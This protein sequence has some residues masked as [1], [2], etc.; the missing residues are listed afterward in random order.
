MGLIKLIED[1]L[2]SP[3]KLIQD[4]LRLHLFLSDSFTLNA[5]L[6]I[7]PAQTSHSDLLVHKVAMEQFAALLQS[8]SSPESEC[9]L[10]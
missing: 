4:M 3:S 5:M 10:T 2:A 8:D 7:E 6:K 9:L 1:L